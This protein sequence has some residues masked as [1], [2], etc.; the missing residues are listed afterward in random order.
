MATK[1]LWALTSLAI[2]FSSHVLLCLSG[3][4]IHQGIFLGERLSLSVVGNVI[5]S[6]V[7]KRVG[8]EVNHILFLAKSVY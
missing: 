2:I 8:G 3:N 4:S 6:L 1:Q 5:E 7:V